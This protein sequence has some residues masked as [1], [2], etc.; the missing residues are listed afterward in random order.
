MGP[1]WR[2]RPGPSPISEGG[3]RMLPPR[4]SGGSRCTSS[5]G[6]PSRSRRNS[7]MRA[8]I[9]VK[10]SAARGRFTFSSCSFVEFFRRSWVGPAQSN[11][12]VVN[13]LRQVSA[14][15]GSVPKHRGRIAERRGVI[16]PV[17]GSRVLFYASFGELLTAD[18]L[19]RG[20]AVATALLQCGSWPMGG[21]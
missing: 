10:S 15:A 4:G 9:A 6:F 8:R 13:L 19:P 5:L 17:F 11:H 2:T 14:H 18:H 7:T 16:A 20:P 3:Q 12:R 1:D 21:A